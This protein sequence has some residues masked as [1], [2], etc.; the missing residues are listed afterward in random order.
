MAIIRTYMLEC[1]NSGTGDVLDALDE[2]FGD[3][4]ISDYL[5]HEYFQGEYLVAT[6]LEV[7]NGLI[8]HLQPE[9]DI[10]IREQIF[11]VM[12]KFV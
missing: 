3:E 6:A 5:Y 11:A 2:L 9:C 4:S 12:E 7:Y 10:V 1:D 8:I